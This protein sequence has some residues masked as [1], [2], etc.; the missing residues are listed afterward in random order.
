MSVL[1]ANVLGFCGGV[2]RAVQIIETELSEHGPLYTLGAIVHNAHV[3]GSL[4]V[5]GA[6]LV[7]SL[8]E[9]P[10]RGTVAITAHGAGEEVYADI[11][12]R[13]LRLVD[14]TC[15][16]V[17]RAQEM[18][19]RLVDEGFLVVLYGEAEH[20]EVHGI[21]SWTRGQ[22]MATQSPAVHISPD[23]GGIA[24]I[25][26]TTKSPA[27]FSDFS[28]AIVRQFTGK[29]QEIRIVDTTCP[30]TGRRYQSAENLAESVDTLL[31]VGSRSSA[32]TRK[33]AETCRATGKPTHHIESADEI[34]EEWLRPGCRFGVTAGASTP[35]S[36]IGDVV[37]KL[38]RFAAAT[39]S[40]PEVKAN[41]PGGSDLCR[42]RS[43]NR[44]R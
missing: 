32:N 25:A 1:K 7:H 43:N 34:V 37:S 31:V 2:R 44:R 40:G 10:D 5:K 18:A 23:T 42:L 15:P 39:D 12:R 27:L 20:P 13:G 24:V 30:E 36:V 29:V 11:E 41:R 14:T 26:Q 3:V 16:I 21:L 33:L 17:R 8:D 4:A 6:Q 38:E 9:V 35:D 19:A 22:G 28:Q